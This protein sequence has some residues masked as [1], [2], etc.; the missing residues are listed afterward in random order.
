MSPHMI[1]ALKLE[2][3]E[4]CTFQ[5]FRTYVQ[6]S[7]LYSHYRAKIIWGDMAFMKFETLWD[8]NQGSFNGI[9]VLRR[10]RKNLSPSS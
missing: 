1:F 6:K 10:F 7:L 3:N 4:L 2:K 9:Q 8:T 5:P